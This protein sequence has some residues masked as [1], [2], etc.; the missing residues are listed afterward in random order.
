LLDA[1]L[2]AKQKYKD[3]QSLLQAIYQQSQKQ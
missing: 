1:A 2:A 3:V